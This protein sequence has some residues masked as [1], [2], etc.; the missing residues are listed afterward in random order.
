LQSW[1]RQP[2]VWRL[3]PWQVLI[4]RAA[5]WLG[6]GVHTAVRKAL[7]AAAVERSVY[8]RAFGFE[9][10]IDTLGAIVGPLT[11]L[12]LLALFPGKYRIVFAFTLLPGL[13]AAV[14]IG[15]VVQEKERVPVQHASFGERL[16]SLPKPYRQLLW[17]VGIFGAGAFA[18]TLLILWAA[19]RLT[20][21]PPFRIA[22]LVF[23]RF[24]CLRICLSLSGNRNQRVWS[25]IALATETRALF[26][27]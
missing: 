25:A 10:A 21:Q 23:S 12:W 9:R 27:K 26:M 8:G 20:Q 24:A 7:L 17:A 16:R 1:T 11:A 2:L 19:E 13:V 14:L 22:N 4:A 5:A 18:H 3:L 6:R 15:L